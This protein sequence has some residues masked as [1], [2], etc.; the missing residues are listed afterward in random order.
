MLTTTQNI[1]ESQ[2]AADVQ[3]ETLPSDNE[4]AARVLQIRQGW[5]LNERIQRRDEA[6]RRFSTLIDTLTE[7]TAA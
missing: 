1:T 6:E 3:N 4:I 2:T 7:S 5:D